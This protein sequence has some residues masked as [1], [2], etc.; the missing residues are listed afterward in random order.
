MA[1]N[2]SKWKP[3]DSFHDLIKGEFKGVLRVKQSLAELGITLGDKIVTSRDSF[4]PKLK[5]KLRRETMP[6]GFEQWQLPIILG[7]NSRPVMMFI[8][9]GQPN[10]EVPEHK[11]ADDSVFRIVIS[12]SI[13]HGGVELTPGDWVF[14][15]KGQTYS[16]KTGNLGGAVM[17]MYNGV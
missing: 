17:H 4:M 11:H 15:P 14:V 10:T 8:T 1:N 6:K 9:V 5:E 12:G 7:I 2:K 13:I 16:F 3:D